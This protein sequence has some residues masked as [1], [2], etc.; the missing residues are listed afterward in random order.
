M[1]YSD[2]ELCGQTPAIH[3]GEQVFS[4]IA[5]TLFESGSYRG[6]A[7]SRMKSGALLNLELSAFAVRD[8]V[9]KPVCYVGIKRDITE[10]QQAIYALTERDRLLAGVAAA[11]HH[12]LTSKDFAAAMQLALSAL[13]K[14]CNVDRV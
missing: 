1:G 8:E 14:A 9:G 7:I 3:L 2:R 12:L 4:L 10:R 11:S 13:G 5:Q 6:E